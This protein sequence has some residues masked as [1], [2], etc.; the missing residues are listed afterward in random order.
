MHYEL[1]IWSRAQRR[2]NRCV[3]LNEDDARWRYAYMRSI[4]V[5]A[6]RPKP[7]GTGIG[8]A[9][10]MRAALVRMFQPALRQCCV[11]KASASSKRV[12]IS[13]VE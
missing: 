3:L 12:S 6:T 13:S 2:W 11:T 7:A 4:G 10:R 9:C 5:R 8:F 1:W